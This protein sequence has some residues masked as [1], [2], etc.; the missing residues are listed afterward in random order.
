MG[1]GLYPARPARLSGSRQQCVGTLANVVEVAAGALASYARRADGSVWAWGSNRY[2]EQGN[3]SAN[4]NL[5]P[6]QVPGVSGASNP[7]AGLFHV[8]ALKA[9]GTLQAWGATARASWATAESRSSL[10]QSQSPLFRA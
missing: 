2:G 8:L 3:G 4:F 1:L 10:R 7:R 9:D 5:Q 6:V